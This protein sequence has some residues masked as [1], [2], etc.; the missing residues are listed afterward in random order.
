MENT[1][2][3]DKEPKSR[4]YYEDAVFMAVELGEHI[5]RSGGEISRAED[6]VNRICRAYGAISVDVTAILSVIVLTVDFGEVSI[7]TSRRIT[8]IGSHNLGRLSRLNALSR[9]ICRDLPS[10][11]VQFAP[12]STPEMHN[13][14]RFLRH[15]ATSGRFLPISITSSKKSIPTRPLK[16]A[17][18]PEGNGIYCRKIPILPQIII[19]ISRAGRPPSFSMKLFFIKPL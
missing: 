18:K 11:E 14:S 10:K 5:M 4:A 16:K 17:I 13:G 19:E 15:A 2:I 6:T 9:K 3:T 1:Q 12:R 8:E 7:S